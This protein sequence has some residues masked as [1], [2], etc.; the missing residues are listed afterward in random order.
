MVIQRWQSVLLLCACALMTV[1]TF[2]SLG[3]W[4]TS[5]ATLDFTSLGFSFEGEPTGGAPSGY[6]LRT[7]YFFSLSLLS[8]VIPFIAIFCYKN[9]RL[10]RRLCLIE[11]L[12]IVAAAAVACILGFGG[13]VGDVQS[14]GWS[15]VAIAPFAALVATILAYR[16]IAADWKKIRSINGRFS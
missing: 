11:I 4:Q 14:Y 15:S 13:A 2:F 10:Q 3:Q 8:A 9:E 1:F 6:Y 7:W 16:R 12:F 5:T